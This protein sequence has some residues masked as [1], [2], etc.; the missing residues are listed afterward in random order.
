MTSETPA[1]TAGQNQGLVRRFQ[2]WLAWGLAIACALYL[3]G[4]IY[5]GIDDVGQALQTFQWWICVPVLLLTLVNYG[6]RFVKWHYLL[7]RLGIKIDWKTD[8]LYFASGLAMVISPGKAGE[9]LKP[10]LV[11]E[12]TGS[13]MAQTIPAL[14]SERL[15]D[16]IAMLVLAAFGVATY[17]SDKMHYITIPAVLVVVG[18][19]VLASDK[20]SLGLIDLFGKIPKVGG[21]SGKLR[22]MYGALRTCL[23]PGPLVVTF[24][25]SLV[26]WWA[27][28]VGY[29]MI[30]EGFGIDAD[31]GVSTFL[32]AFATIAGSAMPGGLG[33]ADGALG[34]GALQLVPGITEAQA[35]G[36]A[37]LVRVATLWFGVGLGA[38]ALLKVA[39]TLEEPIE[40]ESSD[41]TL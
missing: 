2:R 4:S 38:L 27:E 37:I 18:L 5:A 20:L 8:G 6:L 9:L 26:A 25:L 31:L 1:K 12:K 24:L 29:W 23:A 40:I 13:P 21:S 19:A 28:C 7:G 39:G 32:Y 22:E 10:Y 33:V 17:A 15:T 11:R 36:S 14:V 34:A 35:V 30:F 16:G 3:A 41:E